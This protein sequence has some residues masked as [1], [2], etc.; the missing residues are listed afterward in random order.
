[1]LRIAA[2][3]PS[4]AKMVTA[5]GPPHSMTRIGPPARAVCTSR[6]QAGQVTATCSPVSAST[7]V[8]PRP[9]ALVI[10]RAYAMTRRPSSEKAQPPPADADKDRRSVP[11]VA[12][13]SSARSALH[14][15]IVRPSGA[16]ARCAWPSAG[17]A[18]VVSLSSPWSANS[19][20]SGETRAQRSNVGATSAASAPIGV[21]RHANGRSERRS[22]PNVS[23]LRV[24][25]ASP[26]RGGPYRSRPGW[27]RRRQGSE[28]G[29]YSLCRAS[30]IRFATG[31]QSTTSR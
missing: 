27:S 30:R 14:T 11:L 18:T 13:R 7:T 24:A 8:G 2:P 23:P 17:I 16:Y 29:E 5:S 28:E 20:S 4:P 26:K 21:V 3:V 15:A 19:P 22:V 6:E 9:R 10:S 25:T 12:S 1:M 31:S